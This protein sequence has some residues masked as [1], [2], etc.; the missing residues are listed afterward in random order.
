MSTKQL[1]PIVAAFLASLCLALALAGCGGG[2][3]QKSDTQ[4]TAE[5]ETATS[6]NNAAETES[7][8]PATEPEDNPEAEAETENEAGNATE[9]LTITYPGSFFEDDE[10]DSEIRAF[11]E[12]KGYT[13]VT[14]NDDGS[15]TVTMP[16]EVYEAYIA[17]LN[18][19]LEETINALKDPESWPNIA[20]IEH[21]EDYSEIVITLKTN[22]MTA[23]DSF[24]PMSVGI[25]VCSLQEA[26][27][28]IAKCHVVILGS[29][30]TQL[31]ETT[32]PEA[33]DNTISAFL[34]L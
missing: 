24:A 29:D 11:L 21:N 3:N 30:G 26:S 5:A 6:A 2:S 7:E 23:T 19:G 9:T 33:V 28:G 1:K 20:S 10:S 14:K 8:A 4:A 17:A 15:W 12:E 32:Y 18:E 25:P 31:K 27:G 22:K 16:A 34:N 13:N